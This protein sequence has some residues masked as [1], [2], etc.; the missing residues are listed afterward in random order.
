MSG[1]LPSP[2]ISRY[3]VSEILINLEQSFV[4]QV[5]EYRMCLYLK[6]CTNLNP[7][8]NDANEALL[9]NSLSDMLLLLSDRLP[10]EDCFSPMGKR[11]QL[12]ALSLLLL[13]LSPNL[14]TQKVRGSRKVIKYLK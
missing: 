1:T 14:S 13:S 6:I 11:N 9:H 7:S 2:A 4:I 12:Q 5:A 3:E 8:R 10:T